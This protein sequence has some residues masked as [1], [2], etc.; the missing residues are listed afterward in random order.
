MKRERP[1]GQEGKGEP[2]VPRERG[3]PPLPT[4]A[5]HPRTQEELGEPEAPAPRPRAP[6]AGREGVPQTLWEALSGCSCTVCSHPTMARTHSVRRQPEGLCPAMAL[7]GEAWGVHTQTPVQTPSASVTAPG[8]QPPAHRS[9]TIR[10]P[11]LG[12]PAGTRTMY[13]RQVSSFRRS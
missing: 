8:A 2:G 9:P 5:C 6:W 11:G 1:Q 4:G 10:S 3:S 13:S 7:G 12:H